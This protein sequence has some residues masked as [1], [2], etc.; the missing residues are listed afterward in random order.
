[1][2]V[3]RHVEVMTGCE[4][5][6]SAD[7]IALSGEIDASNAALIGARIHALLGA[8]VVTVNCAAVTFLDVAGLRMLVR[9]GV[10]AA[11][12]DTIVRLRCSPAV[13][14]TFQLCES[15]NPLGMVLQ[16]D[17]PVVDGHDGDGPETP[18]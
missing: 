4:L 15:R 16:G 13:L 1:M 17:D 2:A 14:L 8:P 6:W 3:D 11:A 18:E 5:M 10:A 9:T 7:E 12:A